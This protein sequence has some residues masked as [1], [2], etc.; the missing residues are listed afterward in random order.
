MLLLNIDQVASLMYF[1][2]MQ[3]DLLYL[4]YFM[5]YGLLKSPTPIRKVLV[6]TDI[7]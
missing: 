5:V 1:L 6:N 7:H 4:I 2:N 3:L